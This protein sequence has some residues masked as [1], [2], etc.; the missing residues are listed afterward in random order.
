MKKTTLFLLLT[1]VLTSAKAQNATRTFRPFKLDFALGYGLPL[2]SDMTSSRIL[3]LEPK[4]S[5]NDHITIGLRLLD[6]NGI[7]PAYFSGWFDVMS[8]ITLTTDYFFNVN[9]VRPFVGLGAGAFWVPTN[10]PTSSSSSSNTYGATS[11]GVTP[12]GGIEVGHF[13]AA[14]ELNLIRK[15]QGVNF[16]YI[17][18]KAGFFLW[19][20]RKEVT[21]HTSE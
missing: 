4:Y 6:L 17:G 3:A 7:H 19:G 14:V 11:F 15:A 21:N 18:I 13:R 20:K 2:G 16:S 10:T 8:S 5:P 12:R 1:I 9:R